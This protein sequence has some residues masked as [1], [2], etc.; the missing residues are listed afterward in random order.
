MA[1]PI[2]SSPKVALLLEFLREKGLRETLAIGWAGKNPEGN[3][4]L[5]DLLI[6]NKAI[7]LEGTTKFYFENKDIFEV[8]NHIF[9]NTKELLRRFKIPFKVGTILTADAPWRI[10]HIKRRIEALKKNKI[11]IEALDMETSAYY[12]ILEFYRITGIALH[13]ISDEIGWFTNKRPEGIMKSQRRRLS[14]FVEHFLKNGFE[15]IA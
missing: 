15:I 13:F 8:N 5:G 1:G 3:L 10:E 11:D 2:F 12:G 7:S 9:T 14:L 6:P 4:K